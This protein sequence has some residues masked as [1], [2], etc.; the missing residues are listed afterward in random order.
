VGTA[1]R[2]TYDPADLSTVLATAR[3]GSLRYLVAEVAAMPMALADHTP[4]TRA[5]LAAVEAFKKE[6]GQ[7]AID[8]RDTSV[9]HARAIAARLLDQVALRIDLAEPKERALEPTPTQE[10]VIR[11]YATVNGSHKEALRQA[12]A[13]RMDPERYAQENL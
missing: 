5:Q 10:A 6:L 7:Q 3:D 12:E 1:F 2:V 8:R 11:S 9:E 13:L 4:E